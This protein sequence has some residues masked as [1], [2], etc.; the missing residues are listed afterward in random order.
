MSG[1]AAAVAEFRA[2]LYVA[3]ELTHRCNARGLRV[4]PPCRTVRPS[5]RTGRR[6]VQGSSAVGP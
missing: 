2:P 5:V 3:W 1:H 4:V 6:Y